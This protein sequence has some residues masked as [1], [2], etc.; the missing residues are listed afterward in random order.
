LAYYFNLSNKGQGQGHSFWY[1][2]ITLTDCD[3]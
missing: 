1:Q 2:L 3:F